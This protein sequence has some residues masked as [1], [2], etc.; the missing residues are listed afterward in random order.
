M[1][2][3]KVQYLD[4]PEVQ[5]FD[6][7][8]DLPERWQSEEDLSPEKPT[9]D[10]Y[11]DVSYPLSPVP[12]DSAYGYPASGFQLNYQRPPRRPDEKSHPSHIYN[13]AMPL[14]AT[15][16]GGAEVGRRISIEG[17][18]GQQKF[19]VQLTDSY[20]VDVGL[21]LNPV[22][23]WGADSGTVVLNI[24][25][26]GSWGREVRE[27]D[28]FPF[29]ADEKFTIEIIFQEDRY[30]II[31]NNH[32]TYEFPHRLHPTVKFQT[33]V[34]EGDVRLSHVKFL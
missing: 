17:V 10:G 22:I 15:I 29:E 14:S 2:K 3:Q 12:L 5:D 1:R 25:C 31:V 11:P 32:Q 13:P 33:L 21:F 27:K 23:H 30:E 16:P 6:E 9:D 8:D 34:V 26:S 18:A 4:G 19:S 20:Q 28:N 24:R 7:N